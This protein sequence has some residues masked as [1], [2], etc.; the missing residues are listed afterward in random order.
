MSMHPGE[1]LAE[2]ETR[3]KTDWERQQPAGKHP[4][5]MTPA[6]QREALAALSRPAPH[7]PQLPPGLAEK[8]VEA[9]TLEE[10]R[11]C[12]RAYGIPVSTYSTR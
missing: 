1:S 7:V 5:D 9:M 10:R 2:Y 12:A 8:R 6:E 3:L 4:R 11:L